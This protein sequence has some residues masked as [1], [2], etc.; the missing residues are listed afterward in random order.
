MLPE[1]GAARYEWKTGKEKTLKDTG[2]RRVLLLRAL[3]LPPAQIFDL[4]VKFVICI[5]FQCLNIRP[6]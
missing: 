4:C 5:C 1:F 2:K 6:L 3:D